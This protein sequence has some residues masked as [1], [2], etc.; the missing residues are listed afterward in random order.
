MMTDPKTS[1]ADTDEQPPEL[2]TKRL[3]MSGTQLVGGALAAMTA[4][5]IGAQLGVAGTVLGA[6][7]GSVVAGTAGSLYTASLKHTKTKIASAFVGRVG[8][9]PVQIT[10]ASNAS[11]AVDGWPAVTPPMA[12]AAPPSPDPVATSAEIDQ[13]GRPAPRWPWKPILISTAAV[14]LLAIAGIT[15]FELITGQS[16]SGGQGTTITQVGEDRTG[17]TDTP[18]PSPSTEHSTEPTTEPSD[19]P[20]TEPS[21]A[22]SSEAGQA[23]EPTTAPSSRTEPSVSSEPPASSEPTATAAPSTAGA[24]ESAQVGGNAGGG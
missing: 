12:A 6:A 18:S 20:S 5:V 15:V 23:T 7:I 24:D 16:L 8:T 17:G 21:T 14:F 2:K 1:P 11:T 3:D 9:T 13:A 10:S 22:P 19:Q 4:A